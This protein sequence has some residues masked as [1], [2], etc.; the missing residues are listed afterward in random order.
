MTKFK[1]TKD[2]LFG[3]FVYKNETSINYR[4]VTR[5]QQKKNKQIWNDCHYNIT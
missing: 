4:R 1:T 2:S 5:F 3:F